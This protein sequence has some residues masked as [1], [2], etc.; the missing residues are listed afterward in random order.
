VRKRETHT[1]THIHIREKER[2]TV[3]T[4]RATCLKKGTVEGKKRDGDGLLA[5]WMVCLLDG[6]SDEHVIVG[7]RLSN[8]K[9][10]GFVN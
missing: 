8:K 3:N 5:G 4:R 2:H 7:G 10:A 9:G 6:W 1:H